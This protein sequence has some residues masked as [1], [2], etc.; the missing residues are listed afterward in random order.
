MPIA[1]YATVELVLTSLYIL[2]DIQSEEL[3]TGKIKGSG[4]DGKTSENFNDKTGLH[5]QFED[6]VGLTQINKQQMRRISAKLYHKAGCSSA[7]IC[8]ELYEVV[9]TPEQATLLDTK[10]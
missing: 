5:E 3:L 7:N 10:T 4:L 9:S 8:F 2:K 1:R 6:G